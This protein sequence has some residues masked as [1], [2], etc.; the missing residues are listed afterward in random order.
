MLVLLLP[1]LLYGC[2]QQPQGVQPTPTPEAGGIKKFASYDELGS[3]VKA[4]GGAEIYGTGAVRTMVAESVQKSAGAP[5]GAPDM[6]TGYSKTN[7]QVEGVD[8][9]DIVKTDGKY[10]YAVSGGRIFIVDAYPAASAKV[11][12][13]IAINGSVSGIFVDKDRLVAFG[14]AY[15]RDERVYTMQAE[16]AMSTA[17]KMAPYYPYYS[18]PRTFVNVYDISDRTSPSLARNISIDGSYFDSRMIGDYVYAITNQPVYG[19]P[20]PLPVISYGGTE[21]R[22]LATDVYYFDV[23]DSA[24][25][26]TNVVSINVLDG[27]EPASK[28]FLMGQSQTLFASASN[29]YIVYP[30]RLGEIDY[31]NRIID[32]VIL[33]AVPLLSSRI[34][35]IRNSSADRSE[36]MR[37][38]EEA[39]GEH[40]R[41]LNPEQAAVLMR[42]MQE[43]LAAM[44]GEIAKEMEKTFV[45]RIAIDGGRIEYKTN[46]EV[47]GRVLNQFSMDEY[48]GYFR[49]ATT[50]GSDAEQSNHMYVLNADLKIAGKLE[51]LAAG[52]RIYSVRFLGS[53]AYMVTFRQTDPLF[54]IDLSSPDAPRVLGYLKIPGVSDYLHPYDETHIIGVGRD[55]TDEGRMKG[56]KI[57]L[58]DVSDFANPK[59][60]SKYIIGERG[61]DSEAL[62]DHKAF[63]FSREK[64]LLAIP[65]SE[66]RAGMG[67][68]E[69]RPWKSNYWQGAYVFRIDLTD[70][71][72]YKGGITHG[73]SSQIRRSLYI[74][75]VLY[76]VSQSMIRMNGLADLAEINA[77]ELKIT[78]QPPRPPE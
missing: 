8:E 15:A 1:L 9:A 68:P 41:S 32:A 45:H 67:A 36:R 20:I 30:K 43:K 75:D 73:D 70:G 17:E 6:S 24:Y 14:S 63:L 48:D 11:L 39:L 60:M 3:F 76:T 66:Y 34:N 61:T 29:I 26:F 5:A 18:T 38:I 25:A 57:A 69:M 52:E 23:P 46:G 55:A 77:V 72:K 64:N 40:L 58:F 7:I 51:D 49:I 47:P 13:V 54:V 71:I 44:Q 22:V 2:V 56:L 31:V 16:K 35:G 37:Q 21:E 74:G 59:E 12:S 4:S 65:V 42:G 53:K 27:S 33:P 50:T 78:D 19:K 10:V 62:R 28:T